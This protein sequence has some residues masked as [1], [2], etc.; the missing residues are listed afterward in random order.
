MQSRFHVL[1][2]FSLNLFQP[3]AGLRPSSS[4]QAAL[5]QNLHAGSPYPQR[6]HSVRDHHN[7]AGVQ[8][9]VLEKS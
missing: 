4:R 3:L 5:C 6:Q 8:H 9:D 7:A 1:N 2:S